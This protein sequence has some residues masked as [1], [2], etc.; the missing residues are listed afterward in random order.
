[1]KVSGIYLF[2]YVGIVLLSR[3]FRLHVKFN[4]EDRFRKKVNRK[5]IIVKNSR[6]GKETVK[7]QETWF[8]RCPNL[9]FSR[10]SESFLILKNFPTMFKVTNLLKYQ[11][12]LLLRLRSF[13]DEYPLQT[14]VMTTS[15]PLSSTKTDRPLPIKL[16]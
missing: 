12:L 13:P 11:F 1:M 3:R 16:K 9:T 8:V 15:D 4:K 7:H 6:G 5:N 10:F 2:I 14:F